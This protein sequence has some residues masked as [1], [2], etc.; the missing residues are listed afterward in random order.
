MLDDRG[1]GVQWPGRTARD[2]AETRLREP[3]VASRVGLV[4]VGV[5]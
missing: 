2:D 3:A 4:L 5:G 1:R